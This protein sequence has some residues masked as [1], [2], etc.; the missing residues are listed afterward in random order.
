MANMDNLGVVDIARILRNDIDT[1][2]RELT[3]ARDRLQEAPHL[4]DDDYFT[5]GVGDIGYRLSNA[6][7]RDYWS[8]AE[9]LPDSFFE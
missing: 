6:G 8:E 3:E 4:V 5:Q 9:D 7:D 1:A 2:I